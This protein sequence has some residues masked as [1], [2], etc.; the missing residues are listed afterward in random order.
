MRISRRTLLSG[1]V[2]LGTSLGVAASLG[3]CSADVEPRRVVVV[4]AG[5]SGLVAARALRDAGHRVTVLEARDRIGGRIHTARLGRT[6]VDLGASWIHGVTG[7]RLMALAREAGARTVATDA[8]DT[9]VRLADGAIASPAYLERLYAWQAR[10]EAVVARFQEEGEE[11]AS[12]RSVV[13]GGLGWTRLDAEDRAMV[14]YA[15][16]DVEQ[17]YAGSADA[18][19][20]YWFDDDAV[21][22]GGDVLL[23]G[24]YVALAHH[25]ARGLDVRLGAPVRSIVRDGDGVTVTSDGWRLRADHVVVTVPLGVLKRGDLQLELPARTERAIERLGVGPLD[26]CVLRFPRR[27]WDRSDWIEHVGTAASAGRWA[28]WVDLSGPTGAPILM[29]FN[30]ADDARALERLPESAVVDAAMQRLRG[31][32]GSVP[33][34]TASVVTRWAADPWARGSYSCYVVGS[35]PEDRAALREPV[36]GRIHLAGEATHGSSYAT[37]HGAYLSG[38]RVARAIGV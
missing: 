35:S 37:V 30:A 34:P 8:D 21:L 23:P 19:S 7:N 22:R 18:L 38:L 1:P 9:T 3:G 27:F 32:Y 4:G 31:M 6:P 14:A 12:L 29:G 33:A 36:D 2:S 16:N 11:D 13:E 26:K 10:A 17:D 5:M 15:I 28:Q 24:G 25:L 20:A